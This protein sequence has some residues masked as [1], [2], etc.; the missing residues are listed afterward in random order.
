MKITNLLL[1]LLVAGQ[2]NAGPDERR[3]TSTQFT[4]GRD[5]FAQQDR[6]EQMEPQLSV[7]DLDLG[8]RLTPGLRCANPMVPGGLTDDFERIVGGYQAERMAWPFIVKI[9]IGC[10]GS[11]VSNKWIV[12][13]AHCCR[14]SNIRFL[15][16]TVGEYDRG[17]NDV[18]ARTIQVKNK[19]IHPEFV[20]STLRNDICLLELQ[21]E[22][23]FSSVA[24]PVCF[25][26]KN[27]R[28]DHVKLGE[29]PLCYVAGW[30]RIGETLGTARILQETQV[31]IVN[32]TV[33]DAAYTRNNVNEDAMLCAGYAEGGIDACQGDSGGPMICVEGDQPVLRGVVSWG[34]GCARSGLYGVYTRTSSYIDWIRENINPKGL[35]AGQLHTTVSTTTIRATTAA[36][37]TRPGEKK[38]S[39]DCGDPKNSKALNIKDGVTVACTGNTCDLRC[40]AGLKPSFNRQLKCVVTKRRKTWQPKKIKKGVHCIS[41]GSNKNPSNPVTPSESSSGGGF[42]GGANN[43]AAWADIAPEAE[44]RCGNAFS[45]FK[46]DPT[47]MKIDCDQTS[48]GGSTCN[49]KCLDKKFKPTQEVVKCIPRKR[50][51][52]FAPKKA[53]IRCTIP[54]SQNGMRKLDSLAEETCGFLPVLVDKPAEYFCEDYTCHF[55]CSNEFMKP[56]VEKLTCNKR[57]KSW[58]PKRLN[59][60]CQ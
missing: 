41:D 34:I 15:D 13:A 3:P 18:G 48:N 28:I 20:P 2:D 29:G 9:R 40:P 1:P 22:I 7:N 45:Y 32:N 38:I 46:I 33:C 30:G 42:G 43:A 56:N 37:T 60:Y 14:V 39:D 27:S 26:E 8:N 17:A 50:R 12:T 57:K 35:N 59:V 5:V 19:I 47:A 23:T 51:G 53:N 54:A 6:N 25:P 44:T 55:Y 11:I 24:Q 16:V 52:K 58:W 31:P 10:G 21:E 36:P 49:V 4:G